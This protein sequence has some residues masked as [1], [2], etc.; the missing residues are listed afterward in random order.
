VFP[1]AVELVLFPLLAMI[2]MMAAVAETKEEFAGA[3]KFLQ[4][5]MAM[6]SASFIIYVALHLANASGSHLADD[7]QKLALPVWLAIGAL[8]FIFVLGLLMAYE[9]SFTR[10]DFCHWA[11]VRARRRAKLAL[12]LGVNLRAGRLGHFDTFWAGRIVREPDLPAARRTVHA[13]CTE[14]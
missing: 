5:L 1:L 12:L 3:R 2:V 13:F 11:D 8:P 14:P 4:G 6:F 7:L 10:I 9:M